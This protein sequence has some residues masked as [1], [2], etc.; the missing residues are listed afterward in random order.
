MATYAAQIVIMDRGIGRILASLER[1]RLS[2]NT[3]V[4][5]LSDN[6]ATAEMPQNNKNKK[7]TLPTG[8]LGE[9]G[10]KDGYGPMWAAVS[11]TPY[12]QYK[13]ETFDGGLSAPFIIRYPSKIRPESRY[14][15][16]F[17]L[18]DIAPTCLAWAALPIPAHMDSKP[19][20]TYW[21]NPPK[22]PPSK[23][24]DFIPNTCPPRTIFWEHQRNRAALTSQFKLVAPNRGPW[25]VYDIRDRTEQKIWHPGT[26]RL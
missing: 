6:G 17:L 5:F 12:R 20:N 2:D 4:M 11:N 18:Q 21:N 22:L 14:H 10:C 9:V 15:S 3:I 8:P 24:W 1:H 26:R 13:I 25:Q 7:T 19:L 16:P 23:V